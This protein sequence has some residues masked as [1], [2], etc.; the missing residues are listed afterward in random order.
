MNLSDT[1]NSFRPKTLFASISPCIIGLAISYSHLNKLDLKIASIT[2]ICAILLQISSNLIN[3]YYDGKKGTDSKNRLGPQRHSQLS[4]KNSKQ[5]KYMA[6]FSTSLAIIFGIYLMICG[7]WPIIIIGISSVIFSWLYTG[8]PYPLSYYALGEVFAFIFFGPIAVIGTQYLQTHQILNESIILGTGLGFLSSAIMLINNI[9][10]T[11]S[12]KSSN[13]KTLSTLFGIKNAKLIY[14]TNIFL[15]NAVL[16]YL[17]INYN[18]KFFLIILLFILNI[19]LFK[20][21]INHQPSVKYNL[22]LAHTA[23]LMFLYSISTSIVLI[24]G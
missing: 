24:L 16:I 13:K 3:D 7:G 22:F 15:S 10:D 19:S 2:V 17:G 6:L 23:R 9:R 11:D 21:I 8:G 12:D 14:F 5:I 1:I 20:N 4:L 18:S